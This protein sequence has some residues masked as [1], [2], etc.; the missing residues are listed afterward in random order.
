VALFLAIFSLL[1]VL[2]SSVDGAGQEHFH[3]DLL[4]LAGPRECYPVGALFVFDLERKVFPQYLRLRITHYVTIA[5]SDQI[6]R[7]NNWEEK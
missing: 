3:L 6:I 4:G 2:R 1:A 7:C 5:S